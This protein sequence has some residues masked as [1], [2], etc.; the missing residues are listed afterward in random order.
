MAGATEY[1]GY[2]AQLGE[3]LKRLR[4]TL[5]QVP[6]SNGAS[7]NLERPLGEVRESLRE[8]TATFDRIAQDGDLWESLQNRAQIEAE[9]PGTQ[10]EDEGFNQRVTALRRGVGA[11]AEWQ[12]GGG[13]PS[14]VSDVTELK[15]N[16]DD[17]RDDLLSFIAVTN[18]TIELNDLPAVYSSAAE[19][20][21]WAD[22][23]IEIFC[24]AAAGSL[25]ALVSGPMAPVVAPVAGVVGLGVGKSATRLRHRVRLWRESRRAPVRD[26]H[27]QG[28]DLSLQFLQEAERLEEILNQEVDSLRGLELEV[29][30]V[31]IQGSMLALSLSLDEVRSHINVRYNQE[32]LKRQARKAWRRVSSVQD[33]DAA[34]RDLVGRTRAAVTALGANSGALPRDAVINEVAALRQIAT[35]L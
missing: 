33:F 9:R 27:S 25:G 24:A 34:W 35:T 7:D 14:E 3:N 29:S 28:A 13:A 10:A 20:A 15:H 22:N 6:W 31:A 16:I 5:D 19:A 17:L 11:P 21:D 2:S 26:G 1:L 23:L 4:S 18:A 8:A 32:L 30:V 12:S